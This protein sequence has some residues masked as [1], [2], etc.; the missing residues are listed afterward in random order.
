MLGNRDCE[1][2]VFGGGGRMGG[3]TMVDDGMT[4]IMNC[5]WSSL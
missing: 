1:R 2:I 4:V 3:M 5:E